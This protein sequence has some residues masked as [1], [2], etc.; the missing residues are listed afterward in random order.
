MSST[1]KP[2]VRNH[3]LPS[4]C[5]CQLNRKKSR[6]SPPRS[7]RFTSACLTTSFSFSN[8]ATTY[9]LFSWFLFCRSY[10]SSPT[11]T[12]LLL[13][14]YFVGRKY[15]RTSL[16]WCDV[17]PLLPPCNLMGTHVCLNASYNHTIEEKVMQILCERGWNKNLL[18]FGYSMTCHSHNINKYA[19]FSECMKNWKYNTK[20]V[21]TRLLVAIMSSYYPIFS[22]TISI[23]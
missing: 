1:N 4:Y 22:S 18:L 14:M 17:I 12:A 2:R 7:P 19:L 8:S 11:I 3:H 16:G 20:R 10:F 15:L 23:L 9:S 6:K 21:A 13:L 5:G